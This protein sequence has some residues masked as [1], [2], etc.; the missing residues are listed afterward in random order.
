MRCAHIIVIGLLP[1]GAGCQLPIGSGLEIARYASRNLVEAPIDARD[2]CLERE[3]ERH[4]GEQVWADLGK[5]HPEQ[6][7]SVHYGRGFVDGFADFLYA[8][9]NGEPP[10]MPPW[11]YRRA[12]YETPEGTQAVEDWFAGWRHGARMAQASGLRN[13]VITPASALPPPPSPA[14]MQASPER[15]ET[16]P[17]PRKVP[18]TDMPGT[19]AKSTPD[20]EGSAPLRRVSAT[21]FAA[22]ARSTT[23][24]ETPP[25][26]AA[27]D[28]FATAAR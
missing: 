20:G 10:V 2:D 17:P 3:R 16:L 21:E 15:H 1:L 18:A 12:S 11:R 26:K 23:E 4:L 19:A 8:G 5:A 6:P 9:G 13:L 28:T 27:T 14:R 24:G 22:A 7:Y 25:R